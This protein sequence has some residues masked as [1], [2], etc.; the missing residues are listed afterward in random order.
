[1]RFPRLFKGLADKAFSAAGLPEKCASPLRLNCGSTD[2]A[3]YIYFGGRKLPIC[4][5]CWRE[6]ASSG[7]Q[8]SPDSSERELAAE[9]ERVENAIVRRMVYARRIAWINADQLSGRPSLQPP[10]SI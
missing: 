7:L 1:M 9:V 6:T 10:Q 4:W 2:I 3:L 8:W 5:K